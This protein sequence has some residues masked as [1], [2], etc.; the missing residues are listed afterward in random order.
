[1]GQIDCTLAPIPPQRYLMLEGVQ[2]PRHGQPPSGGPEE[3]RKG[4]LLCRVP[5]LLFCL[6]RRS[7]GRRLWARVIIHGRAARPVSYNAHARPLMGAR[8]PPPAWYTGAGHPADG[9]QP[10]TRRA[11]FLHERGHTSPLVLVNTSTTRAGDISRRAAHGSH[12]RIFM[13]FDGFLY[14]IKQ[15][16]EKAREPF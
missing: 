5:F 15:M 1:M 10:H 14:Q 4:T 16:F 9:R 12:G 3:I 13:Y 8:A 11:A 2:R 7:F 6:C